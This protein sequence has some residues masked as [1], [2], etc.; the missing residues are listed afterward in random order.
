[1]KTHVS[2][3]V[4]DVAQSV[5]FY[6]KMFG[7]EPFKLRS[8]YAKF[9]V[10]NPPLNLSMTQISFERGGSLSH[11]GL[12]VESTEEVLAIGKRWVENG[13][14]TLDEMKTDCCYALQDKTWVQDPDGNRW[15]V[16]TVLENTEGIENAASACCAPTEKTVSITSSAKTSCC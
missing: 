13:L 8:D 15:E 3:N 11:L 2:L 5:E 7:I 9:D 14:T 4:K 16:F 10:A 1:M 6:K 12:Q